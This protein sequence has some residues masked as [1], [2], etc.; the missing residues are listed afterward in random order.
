MKQSM[1]PMW[2]KSM[3]Q[4]LNLWDIHDYLYEISENGDCDGYER[5]GEKGES[6]YYQEWSADVVAGL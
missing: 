4:S 3:L 6:G 2:K 1:R 5:E